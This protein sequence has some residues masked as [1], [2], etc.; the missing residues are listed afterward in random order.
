MR[1]SRLIRRLGIMAAVALSSGCSPPPGPTGRSLA[2]TVSDAVSSRPIAGAIVAAQGHTT[3]TGADGYYFT[4]TLERGS[5]TVRVTHADYVP[6]ERRVDV[7]DFYQGE[8]FQLQP[9]QIP[10][11][12]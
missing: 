8:N 3:S 10:A 11:Q 1:T 12:P 6:L 4:T 9:R 7:R 2:G 5:T